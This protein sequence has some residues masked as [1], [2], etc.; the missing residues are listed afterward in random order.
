MKPIKI[1]GKRI[2]NQSLVRLLVRVALPECLR[3]LTKS[4]ELLILSADYLTIGFINKISVIV[5][6]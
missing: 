5:V 3:F 2:L 4:V 1:Q 6:V